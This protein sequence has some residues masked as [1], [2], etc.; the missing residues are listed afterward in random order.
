MFSRTDLRVNA[1]DPALLVNQV[2][3]PVRAP[4]LGV[5]AGSIRHAGGSLDVAQQRKWELEFLH[6]RRIVLD[7]V[8]TDTQHDDIVGDEVAI[9]IAEPATLGR[10][11]GSVSLGIKPQQNFLPAQTGKRKR[12]TLMGLQGEVR[13]RVSD[14]E[15]RISS[16]TERSRSRRL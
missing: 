9:L 11:A 13:C 14:L 4:G 6:E 15:H 3:D 10:S 2:A 12:L 16:E 1:G 7:I 5:V 8:E